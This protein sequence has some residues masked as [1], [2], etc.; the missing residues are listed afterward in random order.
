MSRPIQPVGRAGH[1]G[2]SR[3]RT[4]QPAARWRVRPVARIARTN[5]LS[6]G[7]MFGLPTNRVSAGPHSVFRS[8]IPL[9]RD[10]ARRRHAREGHSRRAALDRRATRS[11]HD[12]RSRGV[13]ALA[14]IAD[15]PPTGRGQSTRARSKSVAE[16]PEFQTVSTQNSLR[17]GRG[18]KEIVWA[19]A[20]ICRLEA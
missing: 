5:P 15:R 12:H 9:Q 14:P 11:R 7:R 13:P 20:P 1:L 2:R 8:S 4:T 3:Y 10:S 18:P 16:P 19:V 6:L 17:S